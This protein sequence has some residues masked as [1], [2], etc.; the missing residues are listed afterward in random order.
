MNLNTLRSVIGQAL[1][2]MDNRQ[3]QMW[4]VR[5]PKKLGFTDM[6]ELYAVMKLAGCTEKDMLRP[7]TKGTLLAPNGKIYIVRYAGSPTNKCI[8][9]LPLYAALMK[10][11]GLVDFRPRNQKGEL[12]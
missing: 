6:D 3:I 11:E 9:P 1:K 7:G 8:Y 2:H 10:E 4:R 5:N 12:I